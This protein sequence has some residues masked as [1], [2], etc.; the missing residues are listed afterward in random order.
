MKRAWQSSVKDA[1]KAVSKTLARR[2]GGG[3]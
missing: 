3:W 2:L 1:N